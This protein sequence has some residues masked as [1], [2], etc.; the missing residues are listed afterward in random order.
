VIQYLLAGGR[1]GPPDLSIADDKGGENAMVNAVRR[2]CSTPVTN[3]MNILLP[4]EAFTKDAVPAWFAI[5]LVA[6]V[7]CIALTNN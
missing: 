1:K 3:Q 7:M 5:G 6:L 4:A 2:G